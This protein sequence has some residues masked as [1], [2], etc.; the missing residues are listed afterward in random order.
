MTFAR[1]K[2]NHLRHEFLVLDRARVRM[3]E[4]QYENLEMSPA[5]IVADEAMLES[6]GP[7]A[8]GAWNKLFSKHGHAQ[9]ILPDR[10]PA[11][12][13]PVAAQPLAVVAGPAKKLIMPGEIK[14]IEKITSTEELRR[15][16]P[17]EISF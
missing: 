15:N 9:L 14:P 12:V 8:S 7:R 17:K 10:A 1:S 5:V 11:A 3:Q 6:D 4:I 16:I 13:P 2:I